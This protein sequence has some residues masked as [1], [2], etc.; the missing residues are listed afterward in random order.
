MAVINE[1]LRHNRADTFEQAQRYKEK[2]AAEFNELNKKIE[3]QLDSIIRSIT[4]FA[5]ECKRDEA[6]K[7]SLIALRQI[8]I[9]SMIEE[10]REK[11][12]SNSLWVQAQHYHN[13]I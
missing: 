10:N 9:K 5:N 6:E 3:E 8:E 11:L 1:R 12:M 13:N 7:A 2:V 4:D